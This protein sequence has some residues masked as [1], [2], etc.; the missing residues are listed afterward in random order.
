IPGTHGSLYID[1]WLGKHQQ[2][3]VLVLQIHQPQSRPSVRIPDRIGFVGVAAADRDGLEAMLASEY[4]EPRE[5]LPLRSAVQT[6]VEGLR[7]AFLTPAKS[8]LSLCISDPV[9][10]GFA[11]A[12]LHAQRA[13]GHIE[14]EDSRQ[15]MS[16][17]V[18]DHQGAGR[19]GAAAG[20]EALVGL[21]E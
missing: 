2:R 1:G 20:D 13:T 16:P 14:L 6:S 8:H 10:H 5:P 12:L 21:D 15:S 3:V 11:R 4:L 7:G 9:T 18:T 17:H 19:K